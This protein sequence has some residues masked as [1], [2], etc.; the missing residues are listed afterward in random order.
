MAIEGIDKTFISK[1]VLLILEV[2]ICSNFVPR[3]SQDIRECVFILIRI[4]I[5]FL[6][7]SKDFIDFVHQ[8]L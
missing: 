4:L 3:R 2:S 6:E 5:G 7:L 8:G 1:K